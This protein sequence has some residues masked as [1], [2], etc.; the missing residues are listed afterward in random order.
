M[1]EVGTQCKCGNERRKGQRY[2]E[3]CH[4]VYMR[5]YMAS[6]RKGNRVGTVDGYDF[7][8]EAQ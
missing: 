2:C 4:R 7:N 5:E 3:E 6:K 1:R 8:Q